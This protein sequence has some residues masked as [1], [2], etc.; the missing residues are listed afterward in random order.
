MSDRS[1]Q[2]GCRVHAGR[3]GLLLLA[4]FGVAAAW[5]SGGSAD[6]QDASAEVIV[7]RQMENLGFPEIAC[8]LNRS[9]DAVE[10]IWVRGLVR[11]RRMLGG[12][13]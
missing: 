13:L 9:V 1:T 5:F 7:L 8:R 2:T 6:A 12:S 3:E 4:I 11:L 10:K